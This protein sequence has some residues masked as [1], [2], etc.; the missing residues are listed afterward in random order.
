[1]TA[2]GVVQVVAVLMAAALLLLSPFVI[3]GVGTPTRNVTPTVV[4]TRTL[5][6]SFGQVRYAEAGVGGPTVVLLHGFNQDLGQ[7]EGVWQLL[8]KSPGRKLRLDLPGFG[9]STVDTFDFGLAAQIERV[10][11]FL[12]ALQVSQAILVGHSMG[13]S[14]AVSFAAAHPTRVT[15]LL[16]LAPSGVPG[17]LRY[18]GVFGVV[19]QPGWGREVALSLA[20]TRLYRAMFPRSMA[21]Q[22][23]SV[24]SSYGEAWLEQLSAVQAPTLVV[25][26]KAEAKVMQAAPE[27]VVTNGSGGEVLWLDEAS[28]HALP[29]TRAELVAALTCAL[30]EKGPAAAV[31]ELSGDLLR[32]GEGPMPNGVPNV[33][34]APNEQPGTN[35]PR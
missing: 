18:P 9:E 33:G 32:P 27:A 11:E 15:S 21:L 20:Q 34:A 24:T 16:L 31:R 22:A 10:R 3:L 14:L 17:A 30:A 35:I 23:A 25:W 6:Q 29:R 4:G 7:W 1:M 5:A 19:T 26:S 8:A 12:D 2:Q 13:A 28:G